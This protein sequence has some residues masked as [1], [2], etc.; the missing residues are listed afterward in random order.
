MTNRF[1]LKRTRVEDWEEGGEA[2]KQ[3]NV[4]TKPEAKH[5]QTTEHEKKAKATEE[6][7]AVVASKDDEGLNGSCSAL[8]ESIQWTWESIRKADY[9]NEWK[10][11][12]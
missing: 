9:E 7:M 11:I 12:D 1:N 2:V 4:S 8:D 10:L 3:K 5:K 6:V